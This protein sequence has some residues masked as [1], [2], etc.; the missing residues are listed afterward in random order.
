MPDLHLEGSFKLSYNASLFAKEHLGYLLTFE[1][2]IDTSEKSGLVFR[3]LSPILE[4]RLYIVWKKHPAFS[5]VAEK[6]LSQI[7]KWRS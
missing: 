4:T 1:N 6:F 5:P 3:P 7:R 2:L